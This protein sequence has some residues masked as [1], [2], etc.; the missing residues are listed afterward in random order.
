[1]ANITA[2]LATVMQYAQ[3]V[4]IQA[5]NENLILSVPKYYA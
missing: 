5:K 2:L 4:K 1:V 3:A